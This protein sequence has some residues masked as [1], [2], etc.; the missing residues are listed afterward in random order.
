MASDMD[1]MLASHA[2]HEL[3]SWRQEVILIPA[4][5]DHPQTRSGQKL[6]VRVSADPPRWYAE[7]MARRDSRAKHSIRG[8]VLGACANICATGYIRPAAMD[9]E[10]LDTLYTFCDPRHWGYFDWNGALR[11]APNG[12]ASRY[13][14][15]RRARD[16]GSRDRQHA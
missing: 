11:L 9:V 16:E 5:P 2:Q 6:R 10:L 3:L 8:Y 13:R 7:L 4:D 14:T 12:Y 1:V 15:L